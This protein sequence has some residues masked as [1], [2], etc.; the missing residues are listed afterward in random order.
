MQY[1]L[2]SLQTRLLRLAVV[3]ITETKNSLRRDLIIYVE[4]SGRRQ[5]KAE[6]ETL[7]NELNMTESLNFNDILKTF[8]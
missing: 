4:E 7:D 6:C 2:H 1:A 8:Y 5:S 3:A